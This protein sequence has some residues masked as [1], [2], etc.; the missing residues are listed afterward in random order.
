M[1][2]F[3]QTVA[4]PPQLL[5][6]P[7]QDGRNLYTTPGLRSTATSV[8]P[9]ANDALFIPF[10]VSVPITVVQIH[11]AIFTSS[12]NIDV[13]IYDSSGNRLVSAGSTVTAAVGEQIFNITDTLL[14]RGRYYAAIAID[15]GTAAVPAYNAL[16]TS[17]LAVYGLRKQA[18]AFPLP[19]TATFAS[20]TAFYLPMFT[21]ELA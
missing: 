7:G 5:T 21:M 20:P 15:N 12:G 1:T 8:W 3:P 16:T 13:G 14:Q 10:E 19:A 9:A 18:T 11:L 17:L 2:D 4:Q 6:I